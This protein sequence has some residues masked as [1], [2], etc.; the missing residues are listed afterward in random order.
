M[1]EDLM[2]D[3]YLDSLKLPHEKEVI[4]NEV[5][6]SCAAALEISD[7]Q[8]ERA[9]LFDTASTCD[10]RGAGPRIMITASFVGE[11]LRAL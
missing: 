4:R 10:P 9:L 5:I 11:Q 6:K 7:E 8:A 2:F 3:M 1:N